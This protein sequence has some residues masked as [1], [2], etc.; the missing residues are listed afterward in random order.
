MSP[1]STEEYNL[2]DQTLQWRFD[3]NTFRLLG[4]ELITDRITAVFEL[5]KNC[6]DANAQNVQ[7]DFFNITKKS[8]DQKII[9][10]D[11]GIG[12][13]FID[14]RDKWM[15][16]GTNSKRASLYSD[17]PFNRKYVGEKG[18]GRFAVDKL[19]ERVQIRTKK[20]NSDK[21]LCVNI[22]WDEYEE[23][24]KSEGSQ[25]SLFT[26]VKNTYTFEN[27]DVNEQGTQIIITKVSD[28]W[29]E[30]DLDR[31]YKELSTLVSPFI[32]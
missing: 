16:V 3:V 25:L 5:V 4:R 10:S 21:W 9:I 8:N 27:G 17:P 31:L 29:D 7:V 20:I 1:I 15:V 11:D 22:N 26:D 30:N 12:M 2:N 19:G 6:Y 13:S 23:L 14:I 18:I 24:S 32:P 28:V